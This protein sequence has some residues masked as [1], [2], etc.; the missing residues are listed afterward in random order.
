MG[1]P[2]IS[3]MIKA[4]PQIVTWLIRELGIV[5]GIMFHSDRRHWCRSTVLAAAFVP[6]AGSCVRRD[7]R[8]RKEHHST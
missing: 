4:R 6:L 8:Q 1:D 2:P 5:S 7:E 3:V